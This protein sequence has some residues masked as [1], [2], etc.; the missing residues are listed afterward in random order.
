MEFELHLEFPD[1][2]WLWTGDMAVPGALALFKETVTPRQRQ[3][4]GK[5]GELWEITPQRPKASYRYYAPPG[6]KE[7]TARWELPPEGGIPYFRKWG[8]GTGPMRIHFHHV[9]SGEQ[10]SVHAALFAIVGKVD[11]QPVE[12]ETGLSPFLV[13]RRLYASEDRPPIFGPGPRSVVRPG[14]KPQRRFSDDTDSFLTFGGISAVRLKEPPPEDGHNPWS[15]S[16]QSTTARKD[17]RTAGETPGSTAEEESILR[18]NHALPILTRMEMVVSANL[19]SEPP[20][21]Q[22]DQGDRLRNSDTPFPSN[23]RRSIRPLGH[24]TFQQRKDSGTLSVG[25]NRQPGSVLMYLLRLWP[26][27]MKGDLIA[28]GTVLRGRPTLNYTAPHHGLFSIG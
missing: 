3:T 6:S 23:Y 8:V 2:R 13:E 10:W 28:P 27:V 12:M 17:L 16:L 5:K 26:C 4:I 9:P 18:S 20:V 21:W 11:D 15:W 14:L 19:V 25:A 22:T 24:V 7:K 1:S